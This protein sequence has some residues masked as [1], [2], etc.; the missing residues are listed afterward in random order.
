MANP[1]R[2]AQEPKGCGI[3]CILFIALGLFLM[4][5]GGVMVRVYTDWVWFSTDVN[6]P[7]VFSTIMG[8]K[9]TLFLSFG[10]GFAAIVILNL[11]IANRVAGFDILLSSK[12]DQVKLAR[13]A[14]TIKKAAYWGMMGAALFV[15]LMFG[16]TAVSGWQDFLLFKSAVVVGETDPLFNQDLGFYLFKLPFLKQLSGS[17]AFV[18][19]VALI[20]TGVYYYFNRA[21]GWLGGLPTLAAMVRPHLLSLAALFFAAVTVRVSLM[22]YD[23]LFSDHDQFYGAGY[24]DIHASLPALNIVIGLLGLT[25]VLCLVNIKVGRLFIL[26]AVPAVAALVAVILGLGAYPSMIQ[27]F[28]VVPNQLEREG[29]FIETHLK[30]TRQAYGLERFK[31]SQMNI[32][33]EIAASDL[34]TAPETIENIR[35]WDYRPLKQVYNSLQALKPYYRFMDIDVDRYRIDGKLRQVTMAVRELNTEGL[36]PQAQKWQNLHLLYTHGYGLVLNRVNE[37]TEEGQPVFLIK[38]LPPQSPE[39]IDVENPAIYFGENTW[40]YSIVR[41][42]LKELDYPLLVGEGQED[43]AYTTYGADGGAPL[44]SALVRTMF[45]LRLSDANILL[46]RDLTSESRLLFRRQIG[47]RVRAVFPYLLFDDD[48]YPVIFNGGI[49][50]MWDAFTHTDAYP[51]SKPFR[52]NERAAPSFNYL[53]NSV[54]VT[55]DAYTGQVE[56]YMVDETDPML[57]AYRKMFPKL[58]KPISEMP[59]ELAEHLRY[60]QS[61]FTVQSVML[62]LYHMTDPRVFFNKEDA[63]T[64]AQ[65]LF[66]GAQPQMMEPYYVIAQLP[67]EP[68]AEYILILPFTPLGRGNMVAWLA[69]R[70]DPEHYGQVLLYRFP[71]E[72][73]VYGPVQ[74]EARISQHPVISQQLNLWNQQVSEVVRGHMLVIPMG[75]SALYIEPLYLKASNETAIPELKKIILGAG[76]RVVMTNTVGEGLQQLLGTGAAPVATATRPTAQPSSG[77]ALEDAKGALSRVKDAMKSGDFEELGRRLKELERALNR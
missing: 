66:Q 10:L 15:G 24:A 71:K 65:E 14:R 55:I 73:L 25:A 18:L 46:S 64:I 5:F 39:D 27:R 54:K 52:Q 20:A 6:R 70:C 7:D 74:V 40:R 9:W 31:V 32:Q 49:T 1:R 19:L 41:S 63:W 28:N 62:Q 23:F 47:E 33:T 58:F 22:R 29:E 67:G 57:K 37:A 48:P 60:P 45:S 72:R 26:P 12:L 3:G 51:Y 61:L 36:P 76:N 50:W 11:L 43:N 77:N 59:R 75:R 56:A 68:K 21:L 13:F 4:I 17:I 30:M 34:A 8:A 53:R 2:T 38:D 69:A 42:K 35:L 16:L 44:S